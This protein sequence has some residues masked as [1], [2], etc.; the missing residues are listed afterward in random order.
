[1]ESHHPA[2]VRAPCV[3]SLMLRRSLR[4]PSRTHPRPGGTA[5]GWSGLARATVRRLRL[6]TSARTVIR[7]RA[8]VDRPGLR[9]DRLVPAR[10]FP[11]AG[12]ETRR[13]RGHRRAAP[14][15][16][17]GSA[18]LRSV[19][20]VGYHSWLPNGTIDVDLAEATSWGAVAC[21]NKSVNGCVNRGRRRRTTGT[22][23]PGLKAVGSR[24]RRASPRRG[25]QPQGN[26][27]ARQLVDPSNDLGDVAPAH[28]LACH[29][30][31]RG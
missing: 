19:H 7:P 20:P 4:D 5:A 28:Q 1:M 15:P 17:R 25:A 31:R 18:P 2:L 23:S 11:S 29:V 14:P 30:V 10:G 16:A 26:L 9:V 27:T 3:C 6:A 21:S 24:T 13:P 22:W 12:H 8:G